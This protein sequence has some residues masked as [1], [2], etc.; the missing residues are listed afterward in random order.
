MKLMH[1]ITVV[2]IVFAFGIGLSHF[3]PYWDQWHYDA[4]VTEGRAHLAHFDQSIKEPD[5][6]ETALNDLMAAGENFETAVK[7]GDVRFI[8]TDIFDVAEKFK[9]TQ[10]ANAERL[11]KQGDQASKRYTDFWDKF[12]AVLKKANKRN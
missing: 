3:I 1:T 11:S 8:R 12:D 10:E 9:A 2:V 4:A 7:Y 6:G 5:G